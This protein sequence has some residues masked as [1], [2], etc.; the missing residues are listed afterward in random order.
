MVPDLISLGIGIALALGGDHMHQNR[1]VG[2][3]GRLE[4]SDHLTDV[5][6][7]DRPHVGETEFLEHRPHL[8]H[9]QSAHASLETVQFRRQ[10]AAHEGQMTDAFLDTAGKELHRWAQSCPVECIGESPDR[11]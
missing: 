7:V 6:A 8:R 11:R 9:R 3:M 2:T 4:G 10:F 5:V 1:T